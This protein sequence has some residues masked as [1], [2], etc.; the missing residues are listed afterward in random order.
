MTD[1]EVV[2]FQPSEVKGSRSDSRPAHKWLAMNGTE[3]ANKKVMFEGNGQMA[4][5]DVHFAVLKGLTEQ[6]V[7]SM[8][9]QKKNELADGMIFYWSYLAI[10]DKKAMPNQI[11]DGADNLS[12]DSL[13]D[14][15]FGVG[16]GALFRGSL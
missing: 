7:Q 16:E 13:D 4:G 6:E 8:Y 1:I 11:V 3:A 10:D 15:L 2:P 9:Q 14:V 12:L 5:R